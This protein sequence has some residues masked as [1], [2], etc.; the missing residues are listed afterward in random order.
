MSEKEKTAGSEAEFDD[1]ILDP[2]EMYVELD[3]DDGSTVDCRIVCIFEAMGQDYIALLPLGENE[4]PNP[5]GEVF[6]YRYFEDEDGE[7]YLENIESDEE[8]EIA[9]DRFDEIQDE[10]LFDEM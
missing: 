1:E 8:F 4:E 3:L 7:P 6:L 9:A 10:E 5:E 2:A